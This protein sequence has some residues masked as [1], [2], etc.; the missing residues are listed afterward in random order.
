MQ[1]RRKGKPTQRQDSKTSWAEKK[2]IKARG[3]RERNQRSRRKNN[4]R[5]RDET[6]K[7]DK[8]NKSHKWVKEVH[9]TI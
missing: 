7:T 9:D 4:E 5:K 8:I 6:A 3:Q 1:K 2:G